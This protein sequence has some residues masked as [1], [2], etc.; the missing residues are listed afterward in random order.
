MHI[1]I[2]GAAGGSRASA[3]VIVIAAIY[4]VLVFALACQ[5]LAYQYD[6]IAG[7]GQFDWDTNYDG[8]ADGWVVSV[9]GGLN[10]EA[11]LARHGEPDS[12]YAQLIRMKAARGQSGQVTLSRS[13]DVGSNLAIRE[14]DTIS[15]SAYL[16]G[17][18]PHSGSIS[19]GFDC[20]D[21]DGY[22]T[23]QYFIMPATAGTGKNWIWRS[24]SFTVPSGTVRIDIAFRIGS[25]QGWGTGKLYVDTVEVTKDVAEIPV[26]PE[27]A[28]PAVLRDNP[29]ADAVYSARRYD[30]Y[31]VRPDHYAYIRTY[32]AY[33]P[34]ASVFLYQLHAATTDFPDTA[35][36]DPMGYDWV[37]SYHPEWF[38]LDEQGNRIR[39][40]DSED[41]YMLDVGNPTYQ[42]VWAETAIHNAT[43]AGA[44]GV[45]IDGI[46]TRFESAG[47]VR[48]VIYPDDASWVAA[49]DAFVRYVVG[50]IS[51][52]GLLVVAGG[53]NQPWSESPWLAWMQILDGRLYESP[54]DGDVCA[55]ESFDN[56]KSLLDSYTLFPDKIYMHHISHP[57][58]DDAV[59]YDLA[60]FLLGAGPNSYVG[61]RDIEGP[62]PRY[63]PFLDIAVG[64]PLGELR[65]I[66]YRTYHRSFERGEIYANADPTNSAT[67]HIPPDMA[68]V[69]GIPVPSGPRDLGPRQ[70]L[71][72]LRSQPTPVNEVTWDL[73]GGVG[74]FEQSTVVNWIS[75]Y[76]GL[77]YDFVANSL[78]TSTGGDG[79]RYGYDEPTPD[80]DIA[81]GWLRYTNQTVNPGANIEYRIS[82]G[83]G[84]DGT[85]RPYFALKNVT[86]GPAYAYLKSGFRTSTHVN[87]IHNGDTV[88]FKLDQI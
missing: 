32:D 21:Y 80:D 23:G 68:E 67:V 19:A 88:T 3:R 49:E 40:A 22:L 76:D 28:I 57:I 46:A 17:T 69:S 55:P 16:R 8:V 27:D 38:L 5:A 4:I 2:R 62:Y 53:G 86:S 59:M 52:A 74:G 82:Q 60:G 54:C 45:V 58:N 85:N 33:N 83:T 39:R 15:G 75:D 65:E 9:E 12:I 34:D 26:P 25:A 63:H 56:W 29:G 64:A 44:D 35:P 72:L 51:S 84:I 36:I 37:E 50:Y 14:G 10:Y 61:F 87:G 73:L 70:G 79:R 31:V 48:P 1:D 24:V 42:R 11:R 30:C 47:G 18:A 43:S 78:Y 20:Y 6:V 41:I 7:L 71:I 77:D 13:L 66:G 81:G